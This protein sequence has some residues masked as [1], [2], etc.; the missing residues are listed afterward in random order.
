MNKFLTVLVVC[1]LAMTYAIPAPDDATGGSDQRPD[2]TVTSANQPETQGSGNGSK[3]TPNSDSAL[4]T[5]NSGAEKALAIQQRTQLSVQDKEGLQN[6]LKQRQAEMTK[7]QVGLNKDEQ[8]ALKNQN[9]VR[10]AVHTLLALEDFTGGIGKN[11]SEIA[12][13][14][15]NS[16]Q[17]T[18]QAEEKVMSKS[19]IAR[20]FSGGDEKTAAELETLVN[21]NKAKIQ[22]LK[23]LNDK[24]DCDDEVKQMMQEQIQSMEQEQTRLQTVATKEK[25]S[26][27]LLGW[28]WK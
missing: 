20:L 1:L 13:S 12:K 5:A 10:L 17:A 26:K 14:F 15:N 11:V 21:Q 9:E 22:E 23:E 2:I 16:I 25:K 3:D 8:S 28:M 24:C 4:Q 7:E 6:A 18:L 27:G 19:G